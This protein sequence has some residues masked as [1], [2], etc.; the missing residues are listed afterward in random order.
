MA[1]E[2][3]EAGWRSLFKRFAGSWSVNVETFNPVVAATPDCTTNRAGNLG[4]HRCRGK[5]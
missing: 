5:A 1:R 4:D 3:R 2:R